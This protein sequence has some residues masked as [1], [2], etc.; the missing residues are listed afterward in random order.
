M[1][2]MPSSQA[3]TPTQDFRGQLQRMDSEFSVALPTHIPVEKFMRVVTTAVNSNPDLMA[4]NRRSLFEAAMRAAQDGLLPDGR[5][6]AL[7]IFGGKVQWMPMIGGI[8]KK[9]RNS[10]E[11]GSI[12]AQ[13]VHQNDKF[14]YRLGVDEIPIHEPDWFG[15]RGAIIG[16]YAVARLKGGTAFAEIMSKKAVEEVRNVS[17]A[18]NSGPWVTWWGEMARKTVLRRLSKRLPMST[19]LDDLIRRD[20]ELYDLGDAKPA[21]EPRAQAVALAATLAAN[22]ATGDK[23]FDPAFVEAEIIGTTHDAETGE[24]KEIRADHIADA[25]KVIEAKAEPQAPAFDLQT[26]ISDARSASM[27][28]RRDFD[29]WFLARPPVERA[30]LEPEMK[31]LMAA[32]HAVDH[33]KKSQ[34]ATKQEPQ[35]EAKAEPAP[36]QKA[37]EQAF[38]FDIEFDAFEKQIAAIQTSAELNDFGSKVSHDAAGWFVAAPEAMQVDA[39]QL[40]ADRLEEVTKAEEA[41]KRKAD[42]DAKASAKTA[43]QAAPP[44]AEPSPLDALVR[45]GEEAAKQGVRR[46]KLWRGK[47]NQA[48]F[49]ALKPEDAR[50]MALA[51]KADEDL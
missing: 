28:G 40:F 50:L 44:A 45:D 20:D 2:D 41:A 29:A 6:G 46:F 33:P 16:V 35:P 31:A 13:L 48:R 15:E 39:R 4:A 38:N 9:L 36:Q 8:L 1:N 17:R 5:D 26:L 49:D 43:E 25:G 30:A 37:T 11:L 51:Q 22:A 14:T 27:D 19:D 42:K 34:P 24:I 3:L 21:I 10:G 7:V 18:K 12:D 23:G 47:L 32:A